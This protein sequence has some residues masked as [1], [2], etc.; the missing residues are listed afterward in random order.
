VWQ[1]ASAPP[2][3]TFSQSASWSQSVRNSVTRMVLP[4]SS[5]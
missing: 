1:Q 4:L 5:P 3:S 2:S